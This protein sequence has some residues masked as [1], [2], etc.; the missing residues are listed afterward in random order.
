M[1]SYDTYNKSK[2]SYKETVKNT[3]LRGYKTLENPKVDDLIGKPIETVKKA[4]ETPKIETTDEKNK[5]NPK[6][7][8]TYLENKDGKMKAMTNRSALVQTGSQVTL[9]GKSI[10]I[11]NYSNY[12]EKVKL[13]QKI[14]ANF[15]NKM[16]RSIIV[17]EQK[18]KLNSVERLSRREG[19]SE[20]EFERRRVNSFSKK[21]FQTL[22]IFPPVLTMVYTTMLSKPG[23]LVYDAFMGHNSRAE[24]V[25]TLGRKYYGYDCHTFP[26]E[27]TSK[28]VSR[29]SQGDYELNLG[30]SEK[31]KYPDNHFDF[32]LT[33]PPYGDV[34]K[35]NDAYEE[36]IDTDLSSKSYNGFL[37]IYKKCLSETYRVLKIGAF[38][39]II[40][41]DTRKGGIYRSLMLD[42]ISICK[43]LG[44]NLHDI[45]IYNRKSNI[46]GDM[47][48][49]SF[50]EVSKRLPTIHEYIIL[51][52]K[53]EKA[54][55]VNQTL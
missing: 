27:F 51:F 28:A 49:R 42:T 41:G 31:V 47:N 45:N 1:A 29:F 23:D 17:K 3:T 35:Y 54:G 24:D 8:V 2:I 5:E 55:E 9:T 16:Y 36:V 30:S 6:E 21:T 11:Y 22:S 33:C 38:F 40:V 44:F 12:Q 7:I 4:L 26:V 43:N 46:G 48:Y 10:P 13:K 19:E 32:S 39:V 18:Q 25:L 52:K 14:I 34:E 37:E 15:N 20:I 53:E 50:I